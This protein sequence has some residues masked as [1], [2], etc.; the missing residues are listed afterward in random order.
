MMIH[1]SIDSKFIRSN[2]F[3]IF[4]FYFKKLFDSKFDLNNWPKA[5]ISFDSDKKNKSPF[6]VKSIG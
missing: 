1:D 3:S 4:F 5:K 2:A 6:G